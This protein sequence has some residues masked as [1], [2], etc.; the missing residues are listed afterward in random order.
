M[1]IKVQNLNGSGKNTPS[2]SCKCDSWIDHWN[3]NRYQ[4]ENKIAGWCRSCREKVKSSDLIGGHVFKT[5][6]TDEKYYITPICYSCNNTKDKNFN[7]E[8]D[9]LVS[10]NCSKCVNK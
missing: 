4:T 7:V 5:N 1:S 9:D 10:A 3:N 6:S 8:L 2:P